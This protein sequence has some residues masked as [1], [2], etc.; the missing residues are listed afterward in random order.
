MSQLPAVI[1]R[2]ICSLIASWC[3]LYLGLAPL[4]LLPW[5][6]KGLGVEE[7]DQIVTSPPLPLLSPGSPST[8]LHRSYSKQRAAI[9]REYGQVWDSFL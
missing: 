1:S 3:T 8:H 9:E 2:T 6:S 4:F 7:K 5:L